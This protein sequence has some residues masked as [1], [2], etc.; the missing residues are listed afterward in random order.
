[1]IAVLIDDAPFCY[2]VIFRVKNFN[3]VNNKLH[4][5]KPVLGEWKSCKHQ[6]RF[7]EAILCRLRIAH[8]HLMHSFLL[9]AK[10]AEMN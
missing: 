6:E 9:F 3:E 8:T 1:M 2:Q 4:L 7:M 10:I 5:I